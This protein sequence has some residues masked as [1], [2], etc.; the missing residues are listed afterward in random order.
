AHTRGACGGLPCRDSPTPR[1]RRGTARAV[2]ER[3]RYAVHHVVPRAGLG[4]ARACLGLPRVRPRC[5]TG[6][7]SV[8]LRRPKC[9]THRCLDTRKRLLRNWKC[10]TLNI[11]DLWLAPPM[12]N[13]TTNQARFFFHWSV[14]SAVGA[15]LRNWNCRALNIND[16]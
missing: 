7:V 5:R 2:V 4:S 10:R 16:L 6:L 3:G 11:N 12:G 8:E 15:L 1:D 13:G 14:R 9:E